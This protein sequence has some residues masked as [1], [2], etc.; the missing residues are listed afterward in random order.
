M[1]KLTPNVTSIAE[2]AAA[3][4]EAGADA[5]CLINTL[6][7]MAVNWRTRRPMLGNVLGGLSGPAIKPVA[8][9]CVHQVAQNVDVPI[10]GIGG[11]ANIDDVMEFLVAG[12]SAVQT[13]TANY[14]DPTVS[15]RILDELPAALVEAEVSSVAGLTRSLRVELTK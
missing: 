3:A 12:A 6:L 14:Y 11:I 1:A 5:V 9:R 7:G 15:M 8:L 10:V 2:I 4:A 13:G